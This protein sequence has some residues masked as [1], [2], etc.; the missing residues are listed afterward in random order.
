MRLCQRVRIYT[1]SPWT[2][3]SLPRR[4][5]SRG[6]LNAWDFSARATGQI[7]PSRSFSKEV[8]ESEVLELA[9]LNHSVS[10]W[11]IDPLTASLYERHAT[12][13]PQDAEAAVTTLARLLAADLR[14][15]PSS[16]TGPMIRL[17]ARLA[18]PDFESDLATQCFGAEEYL[19]CDCSGQVDPAWEAELEGLPGFGIP[20]SITQALAAP[21]RSTLPHVQPPHSH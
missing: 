16:I 13:A 5:A 8:E 2:R 3:P 12:T 21:L 6:Q 18:P 19:D 1:G 15:R 20:D 4:C 10:P 11:Q 17:L 7:S 9:G 14:A